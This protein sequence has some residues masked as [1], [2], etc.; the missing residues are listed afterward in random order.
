MSQQDNFSS[1]F[2]WGAI[3]GGLAGGV[4]GAMLVAKPHDGADDEDE[5]EDLETEAAPVVKSSRRR[6][7][8]IAPATTEQN[9]D[10]ARRSLEDKIASLNDAIDDVRQQLRLV[11]ANPSGGQSYRSTGEED[12]SAEG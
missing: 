5:E 6:P 9:M 3:L 1:G 11:N 10:L 7:L 2:F 12:R 4:V 8:R